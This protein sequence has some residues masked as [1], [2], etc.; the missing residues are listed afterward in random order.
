MNVC[1]WNVNS[2]SHNQ[3]LIPIACMIR[4]LKSQKIIIQVV[5]QK[6]PL[7]P[8]VQTAVLL[9]NEVQLLRVKLK[10]TAIVSSK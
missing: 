6:W 8:L 4:R 2:S 5:L 7:C 10:M 9:Q 3:M 1:S